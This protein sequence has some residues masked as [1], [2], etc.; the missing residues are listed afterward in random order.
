MEARDL[1]T[2]QLDAGLRVRDDLSGH[3]ADDVA[4]RADR[5]GQGPVSFRHE[6]LRGGGGLPC[7]G[8]AVVYTRGTLAGEWPDGTAFGGIRFIDRF[9]V[10]DGFIT[11]QDVWNDL[12]EVRER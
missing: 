1:D 5:L 8:I 6:D 9:E 2:A 3:G 4:G 7:R 10:T 12:A 11:R